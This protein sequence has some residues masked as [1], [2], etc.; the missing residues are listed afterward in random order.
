MIH[1]FTYTLNV[2]IDR[3][4]YFRI[5]RL[6]V[7]RSYVM[8]ENWKSP[9]DAIEIFNLFVRRT[10]V[11]KLRRRSGPW[12][13]PAAPEGDLYKQTRSA[14]NA[15][16]YSTITSASSPTRHASS[17][18]YRYSSFLSLS[19]LFHSFVNADTTGITLFSGREFNSDN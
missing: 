9:G 13:G 17:C 12:A 6:T 14:Y 11:L 3:Y 5:M 8:N 4:Q 16:S 7:M 1:A 19:H 18:E 15:R 2:I 10:R